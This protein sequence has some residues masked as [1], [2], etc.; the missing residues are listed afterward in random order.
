MRVEGNAFKLTADPGDQSSREATERLIDH[1][2]LSGAGL[3][4][5]QSQSKRR[6]TLARTPPSVYRPD[7]IRGWPSRCSTCVEPGEKPGSA[8]HRSLRRAHHRRAP[9]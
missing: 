6:L 4:T 5:V 7:T 2:F 1:G 8:G 3:L 9:P